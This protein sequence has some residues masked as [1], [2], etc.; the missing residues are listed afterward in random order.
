MA[1]KWQGKTNQQLYQARLAIE[2]LAAPQEEL[3]TRLPVELAT[4]YQSAIFQL[5]L[6]FNSYLHELAD[7]AQASHEFEGVQQLLEQSPVAIAELKQLQL[8]QQ[9]SFSWFAWLQGEYDACFLLPLSQAFSQ[10]QLS[11]Q[12]SAKQRLAKNIIASAAS[13]QSLALPEQLHNVYQNLKDLI[14]QQRINQ[15]ES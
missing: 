1:T 9:D 14:E 15:S 13:E 5:H 3:L 2:L 8:L 11:L 6:S 4:Q 7:M 10:W 12:S